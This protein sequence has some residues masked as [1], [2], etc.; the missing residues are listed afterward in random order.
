MISVAFDL[1]DPQRSGIARAA[2]SI[3]HAFLKDHSD[4][5]SVSLAGPMPELRELDAPSWGAARIVDWTEPRYT[6]LGL[7][8]RKAS[9]EIGATTWYFPHWDVPLLAMGSRFVATVNDLA[10]LQLPEH[11]AAKRLV[12]QQWI[13]QTVAAADGLS[14]ISEFTARQVRTLWPSAQHKLQVVPLAVDES[15][16]APAPSFPEPVEQRLGGARYALS[17]GIRKERK[18]LRVGVEMLKQVPELKWVVVGERFP[19][20]EQIEMLARDA[21]VLDRMVVLDRQEESTLRSLYCGAEFLLFPSRYEGF[22]LPILEALAS[23]TPVVASRAASI[24]EVIGNAGW[25]CD[26]DDASCFVNSAR[27]VLDLGA[28]R[29]AVIERGKTR[30]REFTWKRTADALARVLRAAASQNVR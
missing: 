15:F 4:E 23:G 16:Y 28:K 5:F 26:P 8:W 19:E 24:P 2:T 7:G 11:S 30:A 25:L 12:A 29:A 20:W 9:K 10:H 1:R 17:V 14:A 18:N 3:A 27:E 13:R 6:I 22:G 21:G